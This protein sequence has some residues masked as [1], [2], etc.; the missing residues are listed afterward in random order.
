MTWKDYIKLS[1]I[2][3]YSKLARASKAPHPHPTTPRWNRVNPNLFNLHVDLI[4]YSVA[5][6][7]PDGKLSLEVVFFFTNYRAL[8]HGFY[9]IGVLHDDL[10]RMLTIIFCVY[11]NPDY[12]K[13]VDTLVVQVSIVS[14]SSEKRI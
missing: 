14:R 8:K 3:S 5:L 11:T 2:A 1:E 6:K 7:S 4:V 9:R 10:C 12:I 13:V